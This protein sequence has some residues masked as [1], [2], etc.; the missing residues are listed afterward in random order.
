MLIITL[1]RNIGKLSSKKFLKNLLNAQYKE[2]FPP[3]P[4]TSK[5]FFAKRKKLAPHVPFKIIHSRG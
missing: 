2:E 3:N 4:K 5:R 1:I